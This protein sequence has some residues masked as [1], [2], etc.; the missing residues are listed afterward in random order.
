[1]SDKKLLEKSMFGNIMVPIAIILTGALI[2]FGV[3]KMLSSGKDYKDLVYELQSKTFGNRWIAAFELSKQIASQNIPEDELPW[4]IENLVQVHD[5]SNDPRSKEFL[6]VAVGRLSHQNSVKFLQKIVNDAN[7]KEVFQAVVALGN[8]EKVENFNWAK[9][10]E[11]LRSEDQGLKQAA[12]LTL[13]SH[14]VDSAVEEIA[15]LLDD[16]SV[17]IRYAAATGLIYFK[18]QRALSHL[19]EILLLDSLPGRGAAFNQNQVL[20]LKSNVLNSLKKTQWN[21]IRETIEEIAKND[22]SVK[23]ISLARETLNQL[24]N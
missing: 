4:L 9:V 15:K 7:G 12:L 20:A 19:K 10:I 1:M 5:S 6:V 2:V 17:G 13:S 24:K 16:G 21:V 8:K 23:V 11:M 22:K 3:T 18:D 14:K